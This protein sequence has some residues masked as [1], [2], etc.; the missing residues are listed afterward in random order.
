MQFQNQPESYMASYVEMAKQQMCR[1]YSSFMLTKNILT[2][3][4]PLNKAGEWK[5]KLISWG[6]GF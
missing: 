1:G 5:K 4:F 2:I 3:G 6:T